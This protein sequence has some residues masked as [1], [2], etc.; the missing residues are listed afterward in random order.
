MQHIIGEIQGLTKDIDETMDKLIELKK[1]LPPHK[2]MLQVAKRN[3]IDHSFII[4]D[5]KDRAEDRMKEAEL[6]TNI[7]IT[8]V[9]IRL[10]WK[11]LKNMS[12]QK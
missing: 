12:D 9:E 8:K 2:W 7:K 3:G 11:R 10:L 5:M 1:R 6:L 4:K